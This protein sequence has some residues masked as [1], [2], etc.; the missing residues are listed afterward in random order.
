VILASDAPARRQSRRGFHEVLYG[1][2]FTIADKGFNQLEFVPL[3]LKFA[4]AHA[5]PKQ[6]P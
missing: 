6:K 1:N 2:P 3:S 4:D 5:P